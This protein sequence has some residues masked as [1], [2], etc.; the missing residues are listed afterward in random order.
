MKST[1]L[2]AL[3]QQQSSISGA[4]EDC[5]VNNDGKSFGYYPQPAMN[6]LI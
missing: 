6:Y 4:R 3:K 1:L 5:R 2:Q